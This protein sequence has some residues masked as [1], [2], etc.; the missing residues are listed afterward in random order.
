M[1]SF[2]YGEKTT[3]STLQPGHRITQLLWCC[4]KHMW[5]QKYAMTCK[6]PWGCSKILSFKKKKKG[7]A[8]TCYMIYSKKGL[9]EEKTRRAE[10]S[11]L[12]LCFS[13]KQTTHSWAE[14]TALKQLF[15]QAS[16]SPIIALHMCHRL[17]QRA[18]CSLYFEKFLCSPCHIC[19]L[20]HKHEHTAP[21]S[22][23]NTITGSQ[24][25]Y[26]AGIVLTDLSQ[27][28]GCSILVASFLHSGVN[29]DPKSGLIAFLTSSKCSLFIDTNLSCIAVSPQ[30][31]GKRFLGHIARAAMQWLKSN[32]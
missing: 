12:S 16:S 23:K 2:P 6:Q 18:F 4:Q 28:H 15:K 5:C 25:L 24:T 30:H 3:V 27:K 26:R 10:S 17:S 29:L 21:N 8:T 9:K 13:S 22:L 32:A 19:M 7:K 1:S 11:L 14:I 20:K 31:V